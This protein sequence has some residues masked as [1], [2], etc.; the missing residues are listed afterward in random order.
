VTRNIRLCLYLTDIVQPWV[1]LS[2]GQAPLS[3]LAA[4][5]TGSI[6]FDVGGVV[7]LDEARVE[8]LNSEATSVCSESTKVTNEKIWTG[9]GKR[10]SGPYE[11]K[12][13]IDAGTAPGLVKLKV[14]IKGDQQWAAANRPEALEGLGAPETHFVRARTDE[15]WSKTN[16][17]GGEQVVGQIW[18]ASPEHELSV[19]ARRR[20]RD[21]AAGISRKLAR[22]MAFAGSRDKKETEEEEQEASRQAGFAGEG[23][24]GRVLLVSDAG[25]SPMAG[26]LENGG[27]ED[28][29][30][31]RQAPSSRRHIGGRETH[32]DAA[33]VLRVDKPPR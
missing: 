5:A 27:H 23:K 22:G 32:A 13:T 31:Q 25:L 14:L 28:A 18:W 15:T 7:T 10:R 30:R 2:A 9:D 17:E 33:G 1:R 4:G 16:P 3:T 21:V 8:C 24:E 11:L 26:A 19:T 29:G 12:F 20:S 6:M